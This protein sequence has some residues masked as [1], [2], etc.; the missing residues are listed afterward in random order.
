MMPT[1]KPI[2]V[3]FWVGGFAPIGGVETAIHDLAR[4]LHERGFSASVVCWGRKSA[5]IRNLGRAGVPVFRV[6][7]RWGC[8]WILPDRVL[9]AL[10]RRLIRGKDVVYFGKLPPLPIFQ[11]LVATRGNASRPRFVLITP[12]RPSEYSG[13]AA[14][15]PAVLNKLDVIL[16]QAREFAPEVRAFGYEGR[17]EPVPHLPPERGP[18]V[19][20]PAGPLRAGFLGRLVQ[21]KNL[22]YLFQAMR[23]LNRTCPATLELFGDGWERERLVAL[24]KEMGIE[25]LV[26]FH[27]PIAPPDV[28]HAI[29]SC[30]LFVFPSVSEGQPVAALEILARGRP[31]VTTPV[32]AFP[33]MLSDERLGLLGPLDAPERFAGR[34]GELWQRM[35]SEP[36][37]AA[38]VQEAF[39]ESYDRGKLLLAYTR[40]FE[41]LAR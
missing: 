40:L 11:R 32:G 28:P 41:E 3:L 26:R 17:I 22:P 39:G 4:D 5:L 2:S 33:E 19:E 35:S 10:A 7:F 25:P 23:I 36:D 8:R 21:Q 18:V 20:P 13:A 30:H 12:Y 37:A 31:L 24:S 29:D 15:P 38:K 16:V 27:G 14:P 1:P 9:L 6:F 34:I